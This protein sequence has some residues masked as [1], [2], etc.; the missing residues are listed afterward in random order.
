[1]DDHARD[2]KEIIFTDPCYTDVYEEQFKTGK[3]IQ[4]KWS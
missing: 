3:A 4:D 1:M 2:Q